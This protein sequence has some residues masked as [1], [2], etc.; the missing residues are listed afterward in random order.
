MRNAQDSIFVNGGK[1][2]VMSVKKS[3][4]GY[5]GSMSMGVHA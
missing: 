3:G 4:A 5:V 2:G 1:R